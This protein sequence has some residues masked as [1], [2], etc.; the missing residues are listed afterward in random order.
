MMNSII[1]IISKNGIDKI[2]NSIRGPA[3][4]IVVMVVITIFAFWKLVL[5]VFNAEYIMLMIRSTIAIKKLAGVSN[6]S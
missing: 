2:N 3:T 5:G 1:G 6:G 4:I